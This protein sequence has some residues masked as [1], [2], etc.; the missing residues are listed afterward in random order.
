MLVELEAI[1]NHVGSTRALLLNVWERP[2]AKKIIF[3]LPNYLELAAGL[4]KN[5]PKEEGGRKANTTAW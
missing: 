4:Q 1:R 3:K 5:A 2:S